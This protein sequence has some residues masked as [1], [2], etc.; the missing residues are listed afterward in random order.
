MRG[1]KNGQIG[2]GVTADRQVVTLPSDLVISISG[3]LTVIRIGAAAQWH[4]ADPAIPVDA[5]VGAMPDGLAR[6]VEVDAGQIPRQ[7]LVAYLL[8]TRRM[9]PFAAWIA[10]HGSGRA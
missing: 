1:G 6:T 8:Q 9:L 7:G 4:V 3:Q 5:L 10:A 2:N